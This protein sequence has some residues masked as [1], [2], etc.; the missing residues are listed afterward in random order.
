[1]A[2][3]G[4]GGDVWLDNNG[5]PLS[6][7]RLYFYQPSTLTAL[8]TYSDDAETIPNTNPV[9]L[10]ADGRQPDVF[11]SGQAKLVIKTSTN[12]TV[13]SADPV[14]QAIGEYAFTLWMENVV[15]NVGTIVVDA[16]GNYYVS[17]TSSNSGNTPATSPTQWAELRFINVYNA[18]FSYSIGDVCLSNNLLYI[19]LVGTNTGNTPVSSPTQWRPLS[20]SLWN[21]FTVK[22]GAFNA[23]AGARYFTDTSAG[24]FTA[25]L[26]ITP[27][28]GDTV[29]FVDYAGTFN[30]NNLTL[31]RN[32]SEIMNSSTDMAC[33]VNNASIELVYM[34]T[35]GWV[36]I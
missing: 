5:D 35:R 24:A 34:T 11:F 14:G 9:V 21:D 33:N 18:N 25:T 13:D 32:G 4:W 10:D 17:L 22:T 26:P 16:S 7:G 36:L 23:V 29:G 31:G 30:T 28:V 6:A 19:S 1:M 20:G 3:F 15:Y 8:T 12:V 27:T 2:R